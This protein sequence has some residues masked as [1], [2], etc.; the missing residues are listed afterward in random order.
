MAGKRK[1]KKPISNDGD[2][3]L[4]GRRYWRD[5]NDGDSVPI[6]R[7]GRYAYSANTLNLFVYCIVISDQLRDIDAWCFFFC[8]RC[9]ASSR[10]RNCVIVC[11][12][13]PGREVNLGSVI[14]QGTGVL[15]D[16]GKFI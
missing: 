16:S 8:F 5:E 10:S 15:R 6:R 9:L 7:V 14:F 3:G 11:T 13:S 12:S 2:F 4:R 1:E